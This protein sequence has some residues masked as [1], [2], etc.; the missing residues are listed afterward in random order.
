M[1]FELLDN[2][3]SEVYDALH[4]R[5]LWHLHEAQGCLCHRSDRSSED[6]IRGII[7]FIVQ[8]VR[9]KASALSSS[10]PAFSFSLISC[11]ASCA[12]SLILILR[13]ILSQV[14]F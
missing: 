11:P 2:M 9:G 13:S 3:F 6:W 5:V 14:V 7:E 10:G 4:P 12:S 8:I 1:S